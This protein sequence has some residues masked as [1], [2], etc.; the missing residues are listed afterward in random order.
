MDMGYGHHRAAYNL[1]HLAH[2]G[3]LNGNNYKGIPLK[4]KD[5]WERSREFYEFISRFQHIP[6]IG[7]AAFDIYDHL[8]MIPPFYPRRDLTDPNFSL[9]KIFDTIHKKQ[10]GKHL[11]EHLSRKPLPL[12]T[13]FFIIAFMAEIF[14]YPGEIYCVICDAD[15]SRSWVPLKPLKSRIKYFAPTYRAVERLKLYGVPSER[16][17]LTGFPLPKEN[18]GGLTLGVLRRDL[19]ARLA[20]L[21]PK[22]RYLADH[23]QIVKQHLDG[24]NWPL[25]ANHPLTLTFAVGGA[26]AQR[27]LAHTVVHSLAKKIKQKQIVVNLVAGIRRDVKEFFQDSLKECGLRNEIGKGVKI[28]YSESREGYFTKFNQALRRSDIL[29]TKPSELCFFSALGLPIIMAPPIG[30]QEK[31]NRTWL[32]SVGAGITQENPLYANEWLFDWVD[33]G[34]LAE[35]AVEGFLEAPKYGTYNIEKVISHREKETKE[36]KIVLQ[37]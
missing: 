8:Q 21:D 3:I 34:W 20:N 22:K 28:I 29:W 6:V 33:S 9:K 1:R 12:I 23:L 35:A 36:V 18:L 4:D 5:V 2:E 19:G 25:K 37:Y 30:S 14:N 11:I 17:F 31:F 24:H 13:T 32:R 7:K 26:G 16:I 15:F 27:E 10:W